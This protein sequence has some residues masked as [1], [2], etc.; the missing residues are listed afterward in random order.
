MKRM[1]KIIIYIIYN[2]KTA[3]KAIKI[4]FKNLELQSISNFL[5]VPL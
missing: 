3:N 2:K 5:Y 4:P 1:K